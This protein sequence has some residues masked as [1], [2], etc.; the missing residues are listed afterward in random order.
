MA[1]EIKPVHFDL[2]IDVRR[3]EKRIAQIPEKDRAAVRSILSSDRAL[4]SH[5]DAKRPEKTFGG[6]ARPH[7]K[8]RNA[9]SW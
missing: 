9:R 6:F 4:R 1:T 7:G 8:I 5:M 3:G 2:A